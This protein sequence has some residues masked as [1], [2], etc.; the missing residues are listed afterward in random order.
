MDGR[1]ET[2]T[3]EKPVLS[4]NDMLYI[5]HH[6]WTEDSEGY[7]DERQRI[8]FAFVLLLAGYTA[9]RPCSLLHTPP[10]KQEIDQED[11]LVRTVLYRDIEMMIVRNPDP[12][13]YGER[14]HIFAMTFTIVHG[15]GER[16]KPQP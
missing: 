12:T 14:E 13:V 5:L 6:H 11:C 2:K 8:Q 15:K 10:K 1:A 4:G 9:S 3:R 7:R 16:T